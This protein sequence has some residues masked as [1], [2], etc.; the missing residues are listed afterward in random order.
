MLMFAR[1][2]KSIF[3]KLLPKEKT[4]KENTKDSTQRFDVGNK[5]HFTV[6]KNGR[7]SWQDGA[8]TK[9]IENIMYLIKGQ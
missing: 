3:D 5:I 1:K 6:Y 4:Y 2:I 9:R 8:V 7:E